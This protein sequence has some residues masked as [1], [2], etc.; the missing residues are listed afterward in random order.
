MADAMAD[1]QLKDWHFSIDVEGIA[2]AVL[3]REGESTNTL[4]RRVLEELGAIV[5]Q[6]EAM[7]K[8][9]ADAAK[10]QAKDKTQGAPI[11]ALKG[12]VFISGKTTGFIAGAD[13]REFETVTTEKDAIESIGQ[14]NGLLDRIEALPVPVVAAIDGFCLGGG[15][16]LALACHWRIATRTDNTRLGFPEVRLGIFPGFNGTARSI[17]LAGPINA[18]QDMLTGAMLRPTAARAQNLVNEL[19]DSR[20]NLRWAARK[21]VLRRRRSEGASFTQ[22][23]MR[24]WPV[25]GFLAKQMRAKTAEKARADHYPAPFKLIEHSRRTAVRSHGSSA[26]KRKHSRQCCSPIPRA[27]C[28]ASSA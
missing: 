15:L 20:A 11:G 8:A 6:V 1:L 14:I 19:V 16:E 25:R 9:D 26:R 3:D 28:A 4:G 24:K 23:A 21:A 5:E 2:W 13:V 18:M 17:R 10:A 22:N 27:I 7:T 12:L